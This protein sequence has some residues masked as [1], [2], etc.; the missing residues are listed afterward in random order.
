MWTFKKD[1]HYC[2]MWEKERKEG[3]LCFS[4]RQ[5]LAKSRTRL[6][7]IYQEENIFGYSR[8]QN[9]SLLLYN[10]SKT[11]NQQQE[12]QQNLYL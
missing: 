11:V 7:Q 4:S 3:K 10:T 12:Q 8:A 1:E 9:F 5:S 6:L 2:V